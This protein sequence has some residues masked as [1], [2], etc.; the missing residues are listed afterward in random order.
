MELR[1]LER[2]HSGTRFE[3][4]LVWLKNCPVRLEKRS[5]ASTSC[6]IHQHIRFLFPDSKESPWFAALLRAVPQDEGGDLPVW[7]C[8]WWTEWNPRLKMGN[9][10]FRAGVK[11]GRIDR[12]SRWPQGLVVVVSSRPAGDT[13]RRRNA[14]AAWQQPSIRNRTGKPNT[15]QKPSGANVHDVKTSTSRLHE[16]GQ[17]LPLIRLDTELHK[18]ALKGDVGIARKSPVELLR[19]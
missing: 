4:H 2:L 7:C 16:L 6:K 15:R 11:I 1:P 5:T 17:T 19:T 10:V 14:T 13:S 18:A 3:R 12:L 8:C 9:E